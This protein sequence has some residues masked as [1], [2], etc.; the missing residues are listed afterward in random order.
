MGS[1]KKERIKV[2]YERVRVSTFSSGLAEKHGLKE[3]DVR[4]MITWAIMNI[5]KMI[6]N[7]EEIRIK[8]LGRIYFIKNKN[9]KS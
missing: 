7:G 6:E 5:C 3:K 4:K 1:K 9:R 8:G 2:P